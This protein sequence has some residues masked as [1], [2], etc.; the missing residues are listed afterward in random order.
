MPTP[1]DKDAPSKK[2]HHAFDEDELARIWKCCGIIKNSDLLL[3]Q[4]YSGWRPGEF[5]AIKLEDVDLDNWTFKGG[6]K[7]RAGKNRIVP[8]HSAIRSLV[9]DLYNK[10]KEAD[11]EY[12][13][14]VD[15]ESL[16]YGKYR[17]RFDTM[18]KHVGV[19]QGHKPHDPRNTFITLAKKYNVNEYVIKYMV[20]HSIQD[21]TE[22][23]YTDRSVEWL[24]EEI[25]KIKVDV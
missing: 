17:Q 7:T 6:L 15:G 8:I 1:S 16:N 22:R 25:E 3:I 5:I 24:K 13:V 21:L 4:C 20:G 23:V 14:T 11:S 9:A 2:M 10:S 19:G 18:L 12:L